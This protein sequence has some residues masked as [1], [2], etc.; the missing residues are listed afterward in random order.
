MTL[1]YVTVCL[2][3]RNQTKCPEN[4]LVCYYP[5]NLY[6][7]QNSLAGRL[8]SLLYGLMANHVA[9]DHIL[10]HSDLKDC[11]LCLL[12]WQST[13]AVLNDWLIGLH[14]LCQCQEGL[15]NSRVYALNIIKSNWYL[16]KVEDIF[17]QSTKIPRVCTYL[18]QIN[19]V[20]L[21]YQ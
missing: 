5:S 9:F 11:H 2:I 19:L 20:I 17:S 3:I 13:P 21:H 10:R 6:D 12:H 16:V 14:L 15:R 7:Q 1:L 8:H 18:Q 4:L